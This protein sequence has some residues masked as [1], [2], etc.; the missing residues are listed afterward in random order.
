MNRGIYIVAN[1]RVIE[2]SIA[3]LNSI[4]LYNSQ[5]PIFL[6]PFDENYRQVVAA[7]SSRYNVQLV[8]N[9]VFVEQ[10]TR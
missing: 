8:P 6:I 5:V 4:R 9:L 3:L 10:F 2:S 7:R 1:D